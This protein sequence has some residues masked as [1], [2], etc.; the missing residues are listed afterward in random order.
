[1][2]LAKF[3]VGDRV[4]AL[5]GDVDVDAG[6]LG[7]VREI[8]TVPWVHFDTPT[9]YKHAVERL[10]I[11]AG[12]VSAIRD[13]HLELVESVSDDELHAALLRHIKAQR[14]HNAAL[15][16]NEAAEIEAIAAR[17]AYDELVRKAINEE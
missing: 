1:M 7:T 6:Q 5:Q 11:P 14:A 15:D 16:A 12:Y 9:R 10:N 3:K 13:E 17:R 4:R 8:S 2:P